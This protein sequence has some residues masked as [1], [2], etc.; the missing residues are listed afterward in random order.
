MTVNNSNNINK[1]NS[2][3]YDNIYMFALLILVELLT[4]IVYINIVIQVTVRFVDIVRIVDRHCLYKY[5]HTGDCKRT[6]TCMTLFIQTMTVNN[7]TNIN[8]ANSHLYDNIYINNDGQQ[9]HQYQENEQSPCMTIFMINIVIQGDCSFSWYWWN[10]WP[11]LF[12]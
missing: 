1:T 2:H 3:L 8:K 6:V 11:S 4:V 9:F 5:C 10:C 12:I 7:S